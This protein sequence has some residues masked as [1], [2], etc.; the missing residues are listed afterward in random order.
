MG[1]ALWE[2]GNACDEKRNRRGSALSPSL[3]KEERRGG[4]VRK[5]SFELPTAL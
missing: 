5:I 2:R 4:R 3:K 1:L